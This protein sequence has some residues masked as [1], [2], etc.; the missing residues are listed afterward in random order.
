[1]GVQEGLDLVF[2]GFCKG[3]RGAGSVSGLSGFIMVQQG[4]QS[5]GDPFFLLLYIP[6]CLSVPLSVCL[7]AWLSVCLSVCLVCLVCLWG[8]G[9]GLGVCQF[10]VLGFAIPILGL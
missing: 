2:I 10:Q 9:Q 8:L 4:P 7:P 6:V 3:S 5:N 1:M